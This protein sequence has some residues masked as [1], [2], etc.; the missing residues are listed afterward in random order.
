MANLLRVLII[1]DVLRDRRLVRSLIEFNP[2]TRFEVVEAGS[3]HEVEAALARAPYEAVFLSAEFQA[4]RGVDWLGELLRRNCGP[5]IVLSAG[6]S[7]RQAVAAIKRGAQDFHTK[8]ELS[9]QVFSEI[10][11]EL[12]SGNASGG[13]RGAEVE[14]AAEP[15]PPPGKVPESAPARPMAAGAEADSRPAPEALADSSPTV[16]SPAASASQPQ[17]ETPPAPV[18]A[19]AAEPASAPT[20]VYRTD[21]ID[22]ALEE[23][24]L[25]RPE[26]LV[27]KLPELW[28]DLHALLLRFR[29]NPSEEGVA[30]LLELSKRISAGVKGDFEIVNLLQ[31]PYPPERLTVGHSVNTAALGMAIARYC[32]YGEDDE[33]LLGVAGLLHDIAYID[34]AEETMPATLGA[35]DAAEFAADLAQRAGAP[36]NLITTLEQFPE[37]A[38]GSGPQKLRGRE[39]VIDAQV[40][41]LAETFEHLY[42]QRWEYFRGTRLD[43]VRK[44]NPNA[45]EDPIYIVVHELRAWFQPRVLKA[46][47]FTNGFYATGSIVELN[48]GAVARVVSQN[49]NKPTLPV[50]EI[51]STSL[52]EVPQKPLRKDLAKARGIAIRRILSYN[53][54]GSP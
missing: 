17:A 51:I 16:A 43:E 46:L 22:R 47:I 29:E 28:K 50:V 25:H 44:R 39:I 41:L 31:T 35:R 10:F 15:A 48:N 32:D 13:N 26:R 12:R 1:D 42:Y 24:G 45:P 21:G 4:D 34:A 9:V 38:D 54:P 7:V 2:E 27:D 53:P 8:A 23:F 3:P 30:E 33:L 11:R 6:A 18:T 14:R 49:R 36:K 19:A 37:R 52:G 40:L 20:P 5:V